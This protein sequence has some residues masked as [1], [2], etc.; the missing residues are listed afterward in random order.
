MNTNRLTQQAALEL[1]H[2]CGVQGTETELIKIIY[3]CKHQRLALE[4]VAA[5]LCQL[6]NCQAH[7]LNEPEVLAAVL[8]ELVRSNFPLQALHFYTKFFFNYPETRYVEFGLRKGEFRSG[9]RLSSAFEQVDF[10]SLQALETTRNSETT[11]LSVQY[12]SVQ[13]DRALFLT[14]LGE[15]KPAENLLRELAFTSKSYSYLGG[16]TKSHYQ[17]IARDNLCDVLVLAGRLREAEQIADGI[18][19]AYESDVTNSRGTNKSEDLL[20][21]FKVGE[22]YFDSKLYSGANPYARRAVARTLQGKVRFAL[23][24]FKQAEAFSLGKTPLEYLQLAAEMHLEQA[25]QEPPQDR[26]LLDLGHRTLVG[27]AAIYYALLLTRLGK[28]KTALKVLNYLN[29][30]AARPHNEY[31]S[32]I[33][34]AQLALSDVY[35]L[36][37]EY[38][39]AQLCRR[40]S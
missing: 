9:L 34:N 22:R 4:R 40:I 39:L 19:Q 12:D 3:L 15:L 2:D 36:K 8:E 24:D 25:G 21:T 20:S 27:Q 38:E 37:G 13:H 31:P 30:C 17:Y 29:Q 10:S 14:D 26:N 35:R 11:F 33:A 1:L 16:H 23:A 28:L 7:N 32:L 5:L 6:A 18:V